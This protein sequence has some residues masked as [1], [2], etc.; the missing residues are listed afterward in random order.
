MNERFFNLPIEKQQRI[1]NA[2]YKVFSQNSYKRA[3]MSEIAFEGDISKAL[4]Y[5]S[6]DRF[7]PII[8]TIKH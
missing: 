8:F 5:L 3:P 4:S 2:A 6:S 7:T 1:L